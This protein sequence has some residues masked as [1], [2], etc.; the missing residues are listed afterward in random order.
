MQR[1]TRYVNYAT[2]VSIV[3]LTAAIGTLVGS[4]GRTVES[5]RWVVHTQDVLVRLQETVSLV[6][7]VDALQKSLLLD[8]D[9]QDRAELDAGLAAIPR[10]WQ[11]LRQL[12]SDNP[13]QQRALERYRTLLDGFTQALAEGLRHPERQTQSGMRTLRKAIA[14]QEAALRGEEERLLVLRAASVER[15][16]TRTSVATGAVAFL[17]IALL[18]FVR[19][20]ARREALMTQTEQA[21]LAATLR[22]IGDAV[23]ATDLHGRVQFMNPVAEDLA[24]MDSAQAAGR[25]LAEVLRI[26]PA[27]PA[28]LDL[29]ALLRDVVAGAT[30]PARIALSGSTPLHPEA[31]RDW[32][33]S[34]HPM[35]VHGRPAG[36]VIGAHEVTE[37]KQAQR[38]LADA[39]LLLERRIQ[40]RTE[41]LAE[42]NMELRAFA[43]TVAHDLRAPLRNVEG[44]ADALREDESPRL[45][46]Q[47]RH[48]LVRLC[49]AASRMD[50]LITELLAY[51]QLSRA[52]LK[53]QTVDLERVAWLALSD[54]ETQVSR[55]GAQVE[56]AS[57]LPKV[58]GNEAILVQVF[59]NLIG[60]AIKF[61]APGVAPSVRIHGREDGE[62][63]LVWIADNGIGIPPEQRE[64]IFG[65]FERLH[66]EEAYPGTGIGLAIVRKAMERLGGSVRV[67]AAAA[68]TVFR[69]C[70]PMRCGAEPP[71]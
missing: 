31:R 53:L 48:F 34:C 56:I 47:G 43:H 28:T 66:G 13:V 25:P 58:L 57:S 30:A 41:K 24:G 29:P 27:A 1:T 70:L 11:T 52:E 17:S 18:F 2:A 46:E 64:R 6:N 62:H 35:L 5:R 59:E 39:N 49:D 37:L 67:E 38:N 26:L 36:A 61:V 21:R 33:L 44:Y 71:L 19:A 4:I 68:G 16:L 51:S 14:A 50:R 54:I 40:E 63:A 23:I 65:V 22:S 32:I 10:E 69:L 7:Q 42:A 15:D 9:P 55:S 45:S 12:T 3:I 8:H 20:M 60:N